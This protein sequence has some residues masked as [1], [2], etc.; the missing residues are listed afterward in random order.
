MP[1]EKDLLIGMPIFKV[2]EVD[3]TKPHCLFCLRNFTPKRKN[4][5]YCDVCLDK[6]VPEILRKHKSRRMKK[7]W[8][9][10]DNILKIHA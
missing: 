6:K 3:F 2:G 8:E 7:L 9:S 5:R 4:Q 10:V 1:I